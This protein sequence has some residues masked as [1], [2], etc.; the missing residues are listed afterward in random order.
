MD[1]ESSIVKPGIAVRGSNQSGLRAHN[2]RLVLTLIRQ[3]G[4]LPKAEIAR[5]SGLSAQTVSVIMRGLEAEHLLQKGNPLRGRIGQ[6]SIPMRLSASGAYFFGLKVGRS[7]LEL[8]LIDFLGQIV[9]R[10]HETSRFADPDQVIRFTQQAVEQLRNDLPPAHRGRIVGLGIASPFHQWDWSVGD[11]ETSAWQGRDIVD[12]IGNLW[13]FPV[14]L[15]NDATAA[16]GA[17]LVFGDQAASTDFLYVYVGFFVGGG[18]VLNNALFAGPTG[19]AAALGSMPV[20]GADGTARQL[21]DVASLSV[22][23]ARLKETG[24]E[25]AAMWQGSDDWDLPGEL[26]N[27]WISDAA[28]ALTSAITLAACLID[29]P[30]VVL[31]GWLPQHLRD[32]LVQRVDDKLR[33]TRVPGIDL[34]QIRPGS[35][36]RDARTLGAASL[37]LSD[38]FL[39]SPTAALKG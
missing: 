39:I 31:D 19:N 1:R 37:P 18:L 2:E 4:P 35:I 24:I 36:G 21:V 6:P 29:F 5:L 30:Q 33:A 13:D 38:H 32:E 23:E 11:I 26:L 28:L 9:S 20:V 15:S 16:C 10:V 17:E 22:L 34:P 7:S 27:T 14:Y 12:E 8:I 3:M 25:T